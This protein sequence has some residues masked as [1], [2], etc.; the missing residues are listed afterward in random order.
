M[1]LPKL[2]ADCC[3]CG[4]C[5]AICPQGV[6]KIK[7]DIL[8]FYIPIIDH[9]KCISCGR[10]TK[11]C[12]VK[13]ERNTVLKAYGIKHCNP[14]I[15]AKSRSGAFF[16]A[17]SKYIIE[18]KNG[19]VYGS[20]MSE[21]DEVEHIRVVSIDDIQKLQGSKYTQ[22]YI[23]SS[24]YQKAIDDVKEGRWVVFSGTGCQVDKFKKALCFN[25]VS[26]SKVVLID[27]ICHGVTTPTLW[28]DYC[29]YIR[30][31]YK[32]RKMEVG[33]FQFRDKTLGWSKHWESFSLK[34]VPPL[35]KSI[36]SFTIY[37]NL[38]TK[39]F[40]SNLFLRNICFTC[41][42]A[43]MN[44]VSDFTLGDFWGW[45]KVDLHLNKDDKGVSL[46]LM[47]TNKALHIFEALKQDLIYK[48]CT[49]MDFLQPNLQYATSR[50][51][52]YA[53]AHIDY[54]NWGFQ[55]F[56]V[57]YGYNTSLQKIKRFFRNILFKI[58]GY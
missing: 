48:D 57:E 39:L 32:K 27:I 34:T 38:Y 50:P 44:R 4:A 53:Q 13:S 3:G 15:L 1:T 24:I 40:Y 58:Q 28:R 33:R 25:H 9:Q 49:H 30:R 2:C 46:V 41:K 31:K 42:F 21:T 12:N 55:K 6:I 56:V 35:G 22:S 14:A 29:L 45:E 37:S 17:I 7:S 52:K 26:H 11:F 18:Q 51:P 5:A 10:C 16:Y 8:G 47:N 19:V 54:M 23:R 20:Y 36:K 43:N